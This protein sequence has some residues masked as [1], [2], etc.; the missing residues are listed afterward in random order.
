MG[1]TAVWLE[2]AGVGS[3]WKRV[4]RDEFSRMGVGLMS[5]CEDVMGV[6][7]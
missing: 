7:E 1:K 3:G 5:C 6:G 2:L 4:V